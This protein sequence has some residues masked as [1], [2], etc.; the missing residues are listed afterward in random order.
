MGK[1]PCHKFSCCLDCEPFTLWS[2]CFRLYGKKSV[3]WLLVLKLLFLLNLTWP[4]MIMLRLAKASKGFS[5]CF[6]KKQ[7][8][9]TGETDDGGAGGREGGGIKWAGNGITGVKIQNKR[10]AGRTG[11]ETKGRC[12]LWPPLVHATT[13]LGCLAIVAFLPWRCRSM[14]GQR[15]CQRDGLFRQV[16]AG[17][18]SLS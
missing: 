4:L 8:R 15:R 10:Q 9:K 11:M 13:T 3:S 18:T 5:G 6:K 12:C 7:A 2:H 14:R 1:H 17:G 16:K